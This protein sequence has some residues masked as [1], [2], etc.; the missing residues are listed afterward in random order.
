MKFVPQYC[1]AIVG[2]ALLAMQPALA[3]FPKLD[4]IVELRQVDDV[5]T[6]GYTVSTKPSNAL[7][8]PQSVL[9]RNGEKASLSIGKTMTMQWV[10][11]VNSQ[12]ASLSA[13]GATAS[14]NMGGVSHATAT[15]KSGTT[16]K[17]HPTWPGK[18]DAVTVEVEVQ[19]DAVDARTGS[20]LP[21]QSH[22]QA[23]TTVSAV[24]GKW[25]TIASSG[26]SQSQQPGVYST[27]GGSDSRRLLQIRVLAP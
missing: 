8:A 17:V 3:Q 15:M 9:V 6:T 25:V 14:S 10:Q 22:S 11:S 20:E 18:N 7:L 13:A 21:N 12:S 1:F 19:S 16:I 5:E 27:A 23:A 24:L 2:L 26:A 4:L